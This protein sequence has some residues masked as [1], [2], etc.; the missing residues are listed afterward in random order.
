MS[1]ASCAREITVID[2]PASMAPRI[3]RTLAGALAL[4]LTAGGAAALAGQ[5]LRGKTYEGTMPTRGV[6]EGHHL[7]TNTNGKIVLRVSAS[8][9]RVS[10]RFTSSAPL[11]YC[12]AQGTIHVQ[13]THAA[14]ISR[15]GAFKASVGERFA[16]GPGPPGILQVVSGRFSGRSVHGTITT[17]AGEYCGGVASFSARAR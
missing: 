12:H 17:H 2:V 1:V 6:S 15:S 3:P 16:A 14:S 9:K 8:G 11:L 7:G 13:T 4:A 5:P 10:V